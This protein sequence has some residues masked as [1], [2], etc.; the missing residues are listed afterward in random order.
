M[1]VDWQDIQAEPNNVSIERYLKEIK[2]NE[3][4]CAFH[5]DYYSDR[6]NNKFVGI[7]EKE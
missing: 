1:G 4:V 6:F 7:E 5:G 3:A 2:R